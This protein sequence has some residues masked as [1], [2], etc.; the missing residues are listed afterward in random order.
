MDYTEEKRIIRP[1]WEELEDETLIE[2]IRSGSEDSADAMDFLLERY[3]DL[4][5]VKT[6]PYFI[7]GADRADLIQ[8]GMIGLYKATLNY[9]PGKG[10]AFRTHAEQ[11]IMGQIITAVK[12]ASRMKHWPL[13]SYVSLNANVNDD[14]EKETTMMEILIAPGNT[15]PEDQI[16]DRED[17]IALQGAI[18]ARCSKFEHKVLSMYLNGHDYH[19][20]AAAMGKTPKSIDN[21]LQRIKKKV[22]QIVAEAEG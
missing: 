4:V 6:R 5:R 16:I 13:N 17:A 22:Q 3:K 19:Q 9:D 2:M 20:I 12:S 21:A 1:E 10:A 15:T 7:L 11:C 8:E 14:E 18:D